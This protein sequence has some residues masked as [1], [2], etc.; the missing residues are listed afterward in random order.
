MG[1]KQNEE[2]CALN[3]IREAKSLSPNVFAC[4]NIRAKALLPRFGGS[5]MVWTASMLVYQVLLLGG[6]V[7][8][9]GLADRCSGATQARIHVGLLVVAVGMSILGLRVASLPAA[10]ES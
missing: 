4:R 1:A 9:H 10:V 5:P 3:S 2:R 7:Y 6:Y 8:A